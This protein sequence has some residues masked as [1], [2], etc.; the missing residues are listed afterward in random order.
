MPGATS[1]DVDGCWTSLCEQYGYDRKHAT[2]L[3]GDTLPAAKDTER[4]GPARRYEGIHEVVENIWS[5]AEQL[6]G[7]RLA[8]AL[9]L[10]LPHYNKHFNPLLPSQKKLLKEISPATLDRM[11]AG[12]KAAPHGLSGTRPARCCASRYRLREKCGIND[13]PDFWK[14]TAWR[15]VVAVW[16]ETSSGV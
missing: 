13:V 8:P 11:L 10:W 1:R 4:P 5:H 2:K 9:G 14:W 16:P 7:K 12:Q 6:C 3:L 15:T